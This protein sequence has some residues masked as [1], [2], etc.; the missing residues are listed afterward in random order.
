MVFGDLERLIDAL[1]DRDVGTMTTN[2]V[3]P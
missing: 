1:L 3:N 2:F